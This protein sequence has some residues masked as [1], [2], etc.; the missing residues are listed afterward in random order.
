MSHVTGNSTSG[1][2]TTQQF[3]SSVVVLGVPRAGTCVG[4]G[5]CLDVCS[6]LICGGQVGETD[7]NAVLLHRADV[8]QL[9][10]HC[11]NTTTTHCSNTTTTHCSNTTT[12]HCN[13]NTATLQQH[14]TATTTALHHGDVVQH[15][16]TLQLQHNR[17]PQPPCQRQHETSQ[18]QIGTVATGGSVEHTGGEEGGSPLYH[19]WSGDKLHQSG[20]RHDA[21]SKQQQPTAHPS[22]RSEPQPNTAWLASPHSVAAQCNALQRTATHTNHDAHTLQHP[23]IPDSSMGHVRLFC[24]DT[25][26]HTHT[27][28]H[29]SS[30]HLP[31][32]TH[33]HTHTLSHSLAKSDSREILGGQTI[34]TLPTATVTHP[35][36]PPMG[37]GHTPSHIHREDPYSLR[38]NWLVDTSSC[39]PSGGVGV[40]A[41]LGAGSTGVELHH[42]T[43]QLQHSTNSLQQNAAPIVVPA[44]N[45]HVQ[46]AVFP[47]ERWE[48]GGEW[49]GWKRSNLD[50]ISS[51]RSVPVHLWSFPRAVAL[52][53]GQSVS[54]RESS[55]SVTSPRTSPRVW[56]PTLPPSSSSFSPPRTHIHVFPHTHAPR[57]L[58][59]M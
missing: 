6:E 41:W 1:S 37:G 25:H 3:E 46:S 55:D 7:W 29:T 10:Q 23:A 45:A 18:S 56:T 34:S 26:V 44:H 58:S 43:A 24:A 36:T 50:V 15:F 21:T 8:V 2:E 14:C 27:H 47:D 54:P 20:S 48:E 22:P 30:P 32:H 38:V 35:P 9:Q 51:E 33:A 57:V 53:G 28:T 42:T 19:S 17:T 49:G 52:V 39:V 40:A 4:R 12:T 13:N 31:A 59:C 5:V 16:D 11:S